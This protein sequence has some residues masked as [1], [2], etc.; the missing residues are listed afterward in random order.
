MNTF[1][2]R[3]KDHPAMTERMIADLKTLELS[4]RKSIPRIARRRFN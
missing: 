3:L 4:P 1:D 2:T